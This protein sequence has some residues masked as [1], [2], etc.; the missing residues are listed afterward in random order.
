[1]AIRFLGA[2]ADILRTPGA[3][4]FVVAGWFGRIARSTS[5]IGTILL[6]VAYTHSYALAGAVSAAIIIG[7]GITAPLWSRAIDQRGQRAV[8]P[9]ALAGM[10]LSAAALVLVI[11]LGAPLWS[12]FVA[13]FLVGATSIEMGTLVRARWSNVL[14]KPQQRHTALALESVNDELVFVV[15]PPLVTILAAAIGP[16]YGFSTGIAITL[17][18]GLSLVL[19]KRSAPPIARA[20]D[21]HQPRTGL[22][23]RGVLSVIPLYFGVGVMFGAIDVTAIG[24]GR[25]VDKP[26]LAGLILAAFA[27]GSVVAGLIFGPVSAHWPAR[28]RVLIAAIAYGVIVPLLLL[29]NDPTIIVLAVFTSGLVT[30][31]V[32]I[33]ATSLIEGVTERHRLTEALSWPSIGLALGVTLGATFAGIVIDAITPFSG[34]YITSAGAAVV[35]VYGVI[36]AVVWLGRRPRAEA[37][38]A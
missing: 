7:V 9:F 8:V 34:F 17:I 16:I 29:V 12:W 37:S 32:L 26:Y 5:T 36:A 33:S 13:S 15:G 21:A 19:Q 23:P 10:L 6:V 11:S 18:G 20:S 2:Y 3:V 35:G 4:K 30:T 27:C 31:P 14:Q 22:L 38:M 24:I 25:S 28:V 1:V